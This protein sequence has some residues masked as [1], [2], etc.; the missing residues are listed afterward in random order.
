MTGFWLDSE[1]PDQ[2]PPAKPWTL[3]QIYDDLGT[4]S[5]VARALD[6]TQ[7]R[8][9]KWIERRD[10]I[11]CPLPI[12]RLGHIDVYS[13]QEWKAWYGRWLCHW[14]PDKGYRNTKVHGEGESFF[15]YWR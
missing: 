9:N 2:A 8:V 15:T 3:K 1:D 4:K 13:L 6:V 10:K 5:D 7:W 14:E 12:K 11:K